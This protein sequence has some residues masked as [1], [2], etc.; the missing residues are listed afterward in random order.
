[1][2]I[3]PYLQ[4]PSSIPAMPSRKKSDLAPE[5]F[6]ENLKSSIGAVD[7]LQ[8]QADQAMQEGAVNGATRIDET[9]I[10]LEEADLSLRMLLKVRNK[11]LEAYQE[12]MRMQ[13]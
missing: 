10:K 5:G 2:R 1:M 8:H 12:M 13:F 11:A 9:M 7:K 6:A 4:G 3:N